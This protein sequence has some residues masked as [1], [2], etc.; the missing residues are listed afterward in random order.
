M[1]QY[2]DTFPKT[3][4]RLSLDHRFSHE[5]MT[6][7]SYNRGFRSA[8]FV[9][10]NIWVM[11][12]ACHVD[13]HKVLKPEIVDAYEVGLKSDLL[14]RRLRMNMLPVTTTTSKTSR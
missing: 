1:E 12:Y 6:Y 10:P 13:D 3:T 7:A 9:V 14:D 2:E 5:V 11:Q 8:A 4:W